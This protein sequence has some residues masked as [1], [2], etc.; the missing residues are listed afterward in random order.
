MEGKRPEGRQ[1]NENIHF[2]L[3]PVWA[4]FTMKSKVTWKFIVHYLNC[5]KTLF[6]KSLFRPHH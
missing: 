3:H 6:V 4:L 5:E 2:G 1:P